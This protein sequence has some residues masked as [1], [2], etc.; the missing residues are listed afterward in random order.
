MSLKR[1]LRALFLPA[2]ALLVSL[3]LSNCGGGATTGTA[4]TPVSTP[5]P[6][7]TSSSFAYL[8]NNDPKVGYPL[9]DRAA[10]THSSALLLRASLQLR[11]HNPRPPLSSAVNIATG[12]V[13]AYVM[14]VATAGITKIN[15]QS[16]AYHGVQLSPDGTKV[17]FTADDSAGYSQVFIAAL[18]NFDNPIQLTSNETV[19]HFLATFSPDGN[20][21]TSSVFNALADPGYLWAISTLP[22]AGGAETMIANP[23]ILEAMASA[24]TPDGK[25]IVFADQP[26]HLY[27]QP[28]RIRPHPAHQPGLQPR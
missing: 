6:T 16:G 5:T 9:I 1:R 11:A 4:T 25:K 23:A 17:V 8:Q 3:L 20:T 19:D 28:R 21:I 26:W 22:A 2:S 27:R 24:F 18:G 10:P 12:T 13:D 15:S 14:D 7:P